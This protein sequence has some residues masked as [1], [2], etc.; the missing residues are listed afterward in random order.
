MPHCVIR[1]QDGAGPWM[2]CPEPAAMVDPDGDPLC[3]AH[4]EQLWH[5]PECGWFIASGDA[6]LCAVYQAEA[7]ALDSGLLC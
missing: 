6:T 7:D 2:P 3:A 1:T 4:L 5:C